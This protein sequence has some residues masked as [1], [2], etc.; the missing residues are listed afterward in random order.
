[1]WANNSSIKQNQCELCFWEKLGIFFSLNYFYTQIRQRVSFKLFGTFL[2]VD[3]FP[4]VELCNYVKQGDK[5][6]FFSTMLRILDEQ[7]PGL[8]HQCPYQVRILRLQSKNILFYENFTSILGKRFP[9]KKFQDWRSR[10]DIEKALV[11]HGI[12]AFLPVFGWSRQEYF[13]CDGTRRHESKRNCG[14]NY[15]KSITDRRDLKTEAVLSV[16]EVLA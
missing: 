12:S 15:L 6:S 9:S 3:I 5:D 10:E 8:I 14:I 1:M 7:V 4:D 13:Y 2:P 16:N 11:H